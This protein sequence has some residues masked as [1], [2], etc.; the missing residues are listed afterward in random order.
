MAIAPQPAI[1][2]K[3]FAL[4]IQDDWKFNSRLTL[5]LGLRWD[6]ETGNTERFNRLLNFDPQAQFPAGQSVALP[7]GDGT[8]DA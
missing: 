5:N 3:Y 7:G 4:F 1:Q 6:L 2:N 8:G